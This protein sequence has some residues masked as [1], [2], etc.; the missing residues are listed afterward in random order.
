[1]IFAQGSKASRTK[2]KKK[3]EKKIVKIRVGLDSFCARSFRWKKERER[4]L[5]MNCKT[6]VTNTFEG[7][8]RQFKMPSTPFKDF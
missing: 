3:G 5:K 1:M 8:N 6:T 2:E 7:S 4:R